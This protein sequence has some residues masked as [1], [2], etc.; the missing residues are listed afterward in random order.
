MKKNF[1][2]KKGFTLVE[3]IVVLGI[4]SV[5]ASIVIPMILGYIRNSNLRKAETNAKSFYS[6]VKAAYK[7]V[8]TSGA[9]IKGP[10]LMDKTRNIMG[11]GIEK[12]QFENEYKV[13]LDKSSKIYAVSWQGNKN[14]Y[15]AIIKISDTF[16]QTVTSG[17]GEL[18]AVTEQ[19][20]NQQ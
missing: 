15:W 7:D 14:S 5:L 17:T 4:I 9:D 6:A 19:T 2:N 11:A 1:K 16:E 12:T 13:Y 8:I 20:D 18:P 10:E 3:L